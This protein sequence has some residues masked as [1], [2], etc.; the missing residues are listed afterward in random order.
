MSA[1]VSYSMFSN[2]VEP[3]EEIH[4]W[5][6]G[7]YSPAVAMSRSMLEAADYEACI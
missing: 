5:Y 6:G 2:L 1:S 4:P 7:K 3:T